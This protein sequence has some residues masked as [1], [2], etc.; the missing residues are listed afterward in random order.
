M[1]GIKKARERI[2][3]ASGSSVKL[4]FGATLKPFNPPLFVWEPVPDSCSPEELPQTLEALKYVD[5]I[6]PNH[7]E[8]ASLFGEAG[9]D[10]FGASE[11]QILERQCNELL[12]KGF[13]KKPSAVV[14]RRGERGVFIASDTRLTWFPA[15]HRPQDELSDTDRLNWTQKV[16]DPTGGGNAFL[17]GFCRGLLVAWP[18][19]KTEFEEA[20]IYGTVAASFAIK[21]IGMPSLSYT[22]S[23][24]EL[25]NGVSVLERLEEFRKEQKLE[26]LSDKKV[27]KASFYQRVRTKLLGK[28]AVRVERIW[29]DFDGTQHVPRQ[30]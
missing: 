4:G 7:H 22:A 20:A 30:G 11:L 21:Q 5:V 2:I 25:W 3:S 28:D 8:L 13:G 10:P 15:Y 14:V 23:G 29:T 17:G 27:L 26:K 12:T 24:E 6:S 18:E 1:E 9:K 16:V 19:G